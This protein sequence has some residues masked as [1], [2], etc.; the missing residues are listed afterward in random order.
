MSLEPEAPE[1]DA[2]AIRTFYALFLAGAGVVLWLLAGY[3]NDGVVAL[4]LAGITLPLHRRLER[5]LKGRR[6]IAAVLSTVLVAFAVLG[7]IVFLAVSL[8]S[9]ASGWVAGARDAVTIDKLQD[10]L[11]GEGF[12]PSRVRELARLVGVEYTPEAVKKLV[13]SA[14]G[15]IAGFLYEQ[16]NTFLANSLKFFFHFALTLLAYF[17]LLVDG[18]RLK[19]WALRMSPLPADEVV[20]LGD[21]FLS[22]GR[23]TLLGNGVASFAQGLL[24]GI[25]MTVADIPSAVLW[26]TVVVVAAFLPM[27]GNSLVTI[28]AA[29][30]L[31]ADGRPAAAAIFFAFVTAQG[32]L[33]DNVVKTRLMG[34]D[35]RMHDLLIFTSVLAGIGAF[36]LLGV[37]Y[38][39]LVVALFLA[40]AELYERHYRSSLAL[41]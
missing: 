9:E 30:Y 41:R 22:V 35:M 6:A 17:Y 33:L 3:L 27:V 4:L 32:L 2:L 14:T 38:G 13:G 23:A 16:A 25:A 28:P 19:A 15:A 20:F 34:R 29:L 39:P 18:A 26:G 10:V 5:L 12:V 11:F 21:K 31:Y 37:L 7:P 24:V 36:G 8:S 1:R 40:L